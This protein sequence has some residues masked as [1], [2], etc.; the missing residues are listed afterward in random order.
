[1]VAPLLLVQQLI[2]R[3]IKDQLNIDPEASLTPFGSDK[4]RFERKLH[5]LH[6]QGK[7]QLLHQHL[8]MMVICLSAY[9]IVTVWGSSQRQDTVLAYLLHSGTAGHEECESKGP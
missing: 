5:I 4:H 1:M 3:A 6:C 8:Q 7:Q 9:K 2:V